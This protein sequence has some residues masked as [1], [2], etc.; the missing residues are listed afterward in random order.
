MIEL[1]DICGIDLMGPFV[2][3]YGMKYILL[4][5][6]YMSNWVEAIALSNNEGK[7]VTA[8]LKKIIF[9][10]FCLPRTIISDGGSQFCNYLFKFIL[11][12]YSVCHNVP[13][14]YHPQTNGQVEVSN[15]EITRSC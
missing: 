4:E 9:S 11:K 12:K 7:C 14:P 3:S 13:T 2:S 5:M 8:L 10:R 6:D 15:G 1:F